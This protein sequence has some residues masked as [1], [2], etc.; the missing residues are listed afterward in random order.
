MKRILIA[1]FLP[2]FFWSSANA[3]IQEYVHKHA[4]HVYTDS[5]LDD[6]AATMADARFVFLG[7]QRHGDAPSFLMKKKLIERLHQHH[8][9]EVVVFESDFV[10]INHQWQLFKTGKIDA[11]S[12]I[13]GNIALTWKAC[14]EFSPIMKYIESHLESENEL[15]YS[16]MDV[17]AALRRIDNNFTSDL[18]L[19]LD[20]NTITY[21]PLVIEFF[22]QY[23]NSYKSIHPSAEQ[24][25]KVELGNIKSQL[26]NQGLQ[27]SFY[28]QAIHSILQP[29]DR[30]RH[31]AE[32]LKWLAEIAYPNKKMIVWAHNNH[33]AQSPSD[34]SNPDEQHQTITDYLLK[35]YSDD[36]VYTL[37]FTS[38]TGMA[39]G[40]LKMKPCE[41]EK[42]HSMNL[43]A[44]LSDPNS[45]G[46][47]ID[48]TNYDGPSNS[49]YMKGRS[50]RSNLRA[51][52]HEMYDGVLMIEEMYPCETEIQ[53]ADRR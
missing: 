42:T 14:S 7:E 22:D 47:F 49:F 15:I 39:G 38:H 44:W 32:N 24:D 29:Y 33:F 46:S 45:R 5:I 53:G 30:D 17:G 28:H 19:Y 1:L 40:E 4:V 9:F 21:S 27:N 37:A 52:W 51:S 50:H 25:L 6:I 11:A 41:V 31:M 34:I 10:T 13:P 35:S 43:E 20:S 26:E 48:F 12:L 16:A 2:F 8:G 36:E 18:F 3:Q 23:I